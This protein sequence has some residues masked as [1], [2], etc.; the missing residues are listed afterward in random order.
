VST[1]EDR[2]RF[3]G[4]RELAIQRDGE[5]CVKCGM[6]RQKH[7]DTYGCDITVDH[8][9]YMGSS[10]PKHLKNNDLSNLQTLCKKCHGKKDGRM[11]AV[12]RTRCM[13]DLHDMT[14][15][16]VYHSKRGDTHCKACRRT[17]LKA[18]KSLTNKSKEAK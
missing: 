12:R 5:K 11:W 14:G 2:S 9:D 4:N 13:K 10:V 17:R 8:M 1:I 3:G 6:T 16:N 15:D 7:R 18:Q